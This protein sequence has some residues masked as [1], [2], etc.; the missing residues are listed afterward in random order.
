MPTNTTFFIFC[1][2][3]KTQKYLE[4][5]FPASFIKPAGDID[6]PVMHFYLPLF[7]QDHTIKPLRI[8]AKEGS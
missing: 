4:D 5:Q 7:I 3:L 2:I 8:W 1:Y 6:F